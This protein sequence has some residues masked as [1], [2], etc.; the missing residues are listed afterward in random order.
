LEEL[1]AKRHSEDVE[2]ADSTNQDI[3]E[4][5][6]RV[7]LLFPDGA[8][9]PAGDIQELMRR[10]ASIEGKPPT[11]QA[12]DM[13]VMSAMAGQIQRLEEADESAGQPRLLE[14]LNNQSARLAELEKWRT[15]AL[16]A[17]LENLT[18]RL[19]ARLAFLERATGLDRGED[20]P[21]KLAKIEKWLGPTLQGE[22]QGSNAQIQGE[23]VM[24]KKAMNDNAAMIAGL[25]EFRENARPAIE[26]AHANF[27]RVRPLVRALEGDMSLSPAL[28]NLNDRV[29]NLG[30]R[31]ANH[32]NRLC[33]LEQEPHVQSHDGAIGR[34]LERLGE[35]TEVMGG[36]LSKIEVREDDDELR[37]ADPEPREK[38]FHVGER[39]HLVELEVVSSLVRPQQWPIKDFIG[40]VTVLNEPAE[41]LV[42]VNGAVVARA[43]TPEAEG[44]RLFAVLGQRWAAMGWFTA[45]PPGT[46][47]EALLEV[48]EWR[49]TDGGE[50]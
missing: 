19:S 39:V 20:L 44:H 1:V 16:P 12:A 2:W 22:W 25:E 3:V 18:N 38:R 11:I 50:P 32:E 48:S 41:S 37:K 36:I 40:L 49:R 27:N 8:P 42:A 13:A 24:V 47:P 15:R 4:L 21:G 35:V 46:V 34:L 23:L 14:R 45:M 6:G 28:Q 30:Q 29:A 17:V 9:D 31:G 5:K 43:C 26:Q 7:K 33:E 10:V